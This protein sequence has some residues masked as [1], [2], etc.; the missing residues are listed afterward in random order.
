MLMSRGAL[1]GLLFAASLCLFA[2]AG[3]ATAAASGTV[4][5]VN[6]TLRVAVDNT[7]VDHSDPALAYSVLG[8]QIEYETCT[9]LFGYSDRSGTTVS[10]TIS[11]MGAVGWP[12]ISN[13]GKTYVFTVKSG[14]RFSNGDPVTAANYKY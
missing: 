9:P 4:S 10:N 12:V 3:A 6:P 2:G 5:A 11:P 14:M 7:D 13:H 1:K 8:W